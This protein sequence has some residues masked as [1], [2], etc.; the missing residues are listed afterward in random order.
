LKNRKGG[1]NIEKHRKKGKGKEKKKRE[2]Q[3]NLG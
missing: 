3:R 2:E 1:E